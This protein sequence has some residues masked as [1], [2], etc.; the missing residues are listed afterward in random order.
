MT[1]LRFWSSED[2]NATYALRKSS[3]SDVWESDPFFNAMNWIE[4]A[5]SCEWLSPKLL[6]IGNTDAQFLAINSNDGSV[7]FEY[8]YVPETSNRGLGAA[9]GPGGEVAFNNR[10]GELYVFTN[11]EDRP[12]LRITKWDEYQP[13]PFFSPNPYYVEFE[14]VFMNRGC[15]NLIGALT[16]DENPSQAYAWT[17]N[18]G[19]I[20]RMQD[21]ADGMIDV[22]YRDMAKELVKSQRV[23]GSALDAEYVESA[24]AKDSYSNNAAYAPPS[25]LNSINVSSFNLAPGETFNVVYSVNGPLISRGP[26]RCY[27]TIS[28]NDQYFLNSTEDPVIQLGVLGGCLESDDV[29]QFGIGSANVAPVMN[30]GEIGNQNITLWQIDGDDAAYWQ[31]GLFFAADKYRLAWTTESWHAADPDDF[32]NSLLPDPNCFNQCEPYVT[33]APVILAEIS[34]D[35]GSTY[36]NLLG[37]ISATAYIDSVVN[38]DC[39]GT[40][41]DWSNVE[42]PFDN[43]LTMGIK[44]EEFMYGAIDEPLLNNVL[45]YRLNITNRNS[46]PIEIYMGAFQDYDLEANGFD[47]W[48]FDASSQIAWGASC[49]NVDVTNT[50]VYG[51]GKVPACDGDDMI[52]VRTLDAQQA[53]W[54]ADNIALDSMYYWMSDPAEAGRTW[55]T[56][57]D[58]DFPCDPASESDDRDAWM[59]FVGHNFAANETYHTG[60]Y[61]FGADNMDVTNSDYY[62]ELAGI[63]NEFCGFRRGDMNQ[64]G[65][66]DLGDVIS[67]YNI[68]YGTGAGPLF[69]HSMD[70]DGSKIVDGA[71]ILYL[72]NFHFCEGPP[73]VCTWALP[74]ICP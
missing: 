21:V 28:T 5:L 8:N 26:Q 32:W 23:D 18:P 13:V 38:F 17:V 10:Q 61:M 53:M 39:Y 3:G 24:Y 41:W 66:I 72:A 56:G 9:I 47:L 34:H 62:I 12:R 11:Q 30:T 51:M 2:E 22:A 50:K 71:D 37:Y 40:G 27:L 58:P 55:Q 15:A 46:E 67:L 6:Y 59:S 57:I 20:R 74:D 25:W 49:G 64:N 44:V 54:H 36:D 35:G 43:S 48:D 45:V 60:F 69:R 65:E 70:V 31:G 52:G 7:M 68:V 73:P 42:C 14:D 4:G 19:R 16:A 1:T 63:V 29:L 33:P